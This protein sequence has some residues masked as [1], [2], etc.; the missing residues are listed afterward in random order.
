VD[1]KPNC[2]T[3]SNNDDASRPPV[4]GCQLMRSS[5]VCDGGAG[6]ESLPRETRMLQQPAPPLIRARRATVPRLP[7]R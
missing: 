1:R 3:F 6:R 2:A 7:A 4:T 5:S